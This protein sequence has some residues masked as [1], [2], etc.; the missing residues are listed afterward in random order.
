MEGSRFCDNCGS[1][2]EADASIGVSAGASA[3]ASVSATRLPGPDSAGASVAATRPLNMTEQFMQTGTASPGF[4]PVGA[5]PNPYA[6]VHEAPKKNTGMV[7]VF[8]VLA[9]V[10]LAGVGI[11]LFFLLGPGDDKESQDSS[12]PA[13]TDSASSAS[14]DNDGAIGG[15]GNGDGGTP[16]DGSGNGSGTTGGTDSTQ[17]SGS[18]GGN[19][20]GTAQPEKPVTLNGDYLVGVWITDRLQDGTYSVLELG[21]PNYAEYGVTTIRFTNEGDKTPTIEEQKTRWQ[22]RQWEYAYNEKEYGLYSLD[23][24]TLSL[25]TGENDVFYAI[26]LVDANTMSLNSG[27]GE[28][29]M[30]RIGDT[31]FL[32]E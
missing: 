2:V 28:M 6:R 30:Y 1:P 17:S 3:S 32:F 27:Y 21:V 10:L 16:D 23:G 8:V 14:S 5:A 19:G 11:G 13:I 7:I 29:P 12:T 4:A 9:V 18:T 24:T 25:Y 22:N 20:N 31:P 15:D 26:T